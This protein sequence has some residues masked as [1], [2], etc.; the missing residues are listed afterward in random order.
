MTGVRPAKLFFTFIATL[1]LCVGAFAG[2]A[3]PPLWHVTSDK[4]S[5]TLIGSVH[6]LPPNLDWQSADIR[7]AMAAADV[8]VAEVPVDEKMTG[9]ITGAVQSRGDLPV[10]ESLRSHLTLEGNRE[11]D[12]QIKAL[13]WQSDAVMTKRPWVVALMLDMEQMRAAGQTQPGPDVTLIAQA[14]AAGKTVRY[15][16]TPAAQMALLAPQDEE[17][18]RQLLE[19]SL[20]DYDSAKEE[21]QTL[22][23]A[24]AAGD[25][26]AV[27][28]IIGRDMAQYPRLRDV[29]FTQRNADW[30]KQIRAML[31][32][33]RHFVI[34]VGVGH[35]VGTG[36]VPALLKAAGYT[37]DGP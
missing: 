32:E 23:K 22:T 35:L 14:R 6:L 18:E 2:A 34:V 11:L 19:S 12:K 4:A 26:P 3:Q 16:E 17:L 7:A 1:F 10:G 30:V 33:H 21:L 13:G 15:L 28:A 36:S 24:W 9:L 5:V 8:V 37:V 20:K 31:G 27:A 25:A 29:F